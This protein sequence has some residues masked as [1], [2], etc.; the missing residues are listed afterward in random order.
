MALL[1]RHPVS[2]WQVIR[3]P[4]LGVRVPMW[5][6]GSRLPSLV[7]DEPRVAVAAV[8]ERPGGAVTVANTHL[9]FVPWSNGR[10][11]RGLVVA[12]RDV[13]RPLLLAGDLNMR[14]DRASAITGMRPLVASSTFPVDRP[15]EQIDHVLADGSF[16]VALAEARRLPLSDHR[17]LVV[18]LA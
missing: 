9:S 4:A 2:A 7:R 6:R 11:L 1:S 15:R 17:A 5:V 8:V 10:Q 16:R 12:L 14:A 18:D 13:P 3:L